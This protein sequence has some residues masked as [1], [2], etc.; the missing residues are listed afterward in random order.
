MAARFYLERY[1]GR[2][3]KADEIVECPMVLTCLHRNEMHSIIVAVDGACRN[4]GQ[5]GAQA[6]LGVFFRA[7]SSWNKAEKLTLRD[8][9][10]QRAE[11]CAALRA[12]KIVYDS[13]AHEWQH[14]I[15]A[16]S[17]LKRVIIKSDSNYL[18]QGMTEHI[19]KWRSN[20]FLNARSQPVQNQELIKEI[21]QLIK[22]LQQ[23]KKIRVLFWKVARQDNANADRLANL[24]LD[25]TRVP[26]W[27]YRGPSV[28]RPD[29]AIERV[30]LWH[31][32][33]GHIPL[34]ELQ[35]TLRVTK[36]MD[37]THEQIQAVI[38]KGVPCPV[39]VS[40]KMSFRS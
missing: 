25:T 26:T 37:I 10:S 17:A 31:N 23:Q 7:G 32:R 19:V 9:T 4:N 34:L 13:I 33:L 27:D 1:I 5:P 29:P 11:L 3:L 36:G 22:R 12:L 6:A 39:C 30:W 35:L 24:A 8:T 2:A 21:W 14:S 18:V 28:M 38:D 15:T 20:G 16:G 40:Y